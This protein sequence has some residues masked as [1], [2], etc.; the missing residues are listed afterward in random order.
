M[1]TTDAQ[2]DGVGFPVRDEGRDTGDE[3]RH[4][5]RDRPTTDQIADSGSHQDDEGDEGHHEQ[6]AASLVRTYFFE[7]GDLRTTR[8]EGSGRRLRLRRTLDA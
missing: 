4:H 2:G 8:T 1:G 3:D 7:H 6:H 5:Q